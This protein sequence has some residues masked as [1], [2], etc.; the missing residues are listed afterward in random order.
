MNETQSENDEKS[1]LT[2]GDWERMS[3]NCV[4]KKMPKGNFQGIEKWNIGSETWGSFVWTVTSVQL[5]LMTKYIKIKSL[6]V[7]TTV[8]NTGQVIQV[9]QGEQGDSNYQLAHGP[10]ITMTKNWEQ[11]NIAVNIWLELYH[12]SHFS[13]FRF[14]SITKYQEIF[15]I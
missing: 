4:I 9:E 7:P 13:S 1:T 8:H 5:S 2:T 3:V 12:R 15:R 10:Q 14:S 6:S 11:F